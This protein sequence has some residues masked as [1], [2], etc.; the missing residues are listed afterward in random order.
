MKGNDIIAAQFGNNVR[1][2]GAAAGH[3]VGVA[4]AEENGGQHTLTKPFGLLQ[5]CRYAGQLLIA[6]TV[7]LCG[8]EIRLQHNVGKEIKR[9]RQVGGE[10]R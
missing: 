1:I 9:W 3:A 10:G 5:L 6:E 2:A 4:G 7:H 8:G